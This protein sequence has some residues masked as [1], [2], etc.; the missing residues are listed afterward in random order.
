MT[1]TG[2]MENSFKQALK[3]PP[4]LRTAEVS[5]LAKLC[6]LGLNFSSQKAKVAYC[7]SLAGVI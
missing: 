2:S 5:K 7:P 6:V 3:K 4:S 1:M